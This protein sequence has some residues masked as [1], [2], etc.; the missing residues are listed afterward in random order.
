MAAWR[1]RLLSLAFSA[2]SIRLLLQL[3]AGVAL[4][5]L[6]SAAAPT[7]ALEA[8][9]LQ[10]VAAAGSNGVHALGA[11][12]KAGVTAFRTVAKDPVPENP[13]YHLRQ[14]RKSVGILYRG[15]GVSVIGAAPVFSLYF[16][17]F[18]VA[19]RAEPLSAPWPSP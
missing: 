9:L 13:L 16:G 1:R 11:G 18:E 15:F 19:Q 4:R 7:A 6:R 3:G 14:L 12:V 2:D 5:V 8:P 17:G 10:R